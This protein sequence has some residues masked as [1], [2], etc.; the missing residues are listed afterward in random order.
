MKE[1]L[2][3]YDGRNQVCRVRCGRRGKARRCSTELRTHCTAPSGRG[4]EPVKGE[5]RRGAAAS[6]TTG[7]WQRKGTILGVWPMDRRAQLAAWGPGSGVN[8]RV[9][10]SG[11][12]PLSAEVSPRAE[13]RCSEKCRSWNPPVMS[14]LF[15]DAVPGKA[16]KEVNG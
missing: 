15:L 4:R 2:K 3:A 5:V 13:H 8:G 12:R 6:G 14:S 1:R 9:S 7:I 16:Q 11:R 10:G